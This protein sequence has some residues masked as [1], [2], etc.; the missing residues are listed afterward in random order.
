[1]LKQSYFKEYKENSGGGIV[2]LKIKGFFANMMLA[3]LTW[4]MFP[5]AR[6]FICSISVV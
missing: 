6:A 5:L 1:M 2:F 3:T 4:S